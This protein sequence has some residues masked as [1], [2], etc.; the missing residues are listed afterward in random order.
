MTCA[1]SSKTLLIWHPSLGNFQFSVQHRKSEN[2]GQA[3]EISFL[4]GIWRLAGLS[5]LLD[6]VQSVMNAGWIVIVS[7][8]MQ[9][10]CLANSRG[11]IWDHS[12]L[13]NCNCGSQ[14]R[15]LLLVQLCG[16]LK[17]S[18]TFQSNERAVQMELGS[19]L[20]SFC[21][22]FLFLNALPSLRSSWLSHLINQ[23]S[24]QGQWSRAEQT[25]G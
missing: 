20:G 5:E 23:L 16:N 1:W 24:S 4:C 10:I 21:C 2:R 8:H 25:A 11:Q 19:S 7:G 18:W 17:T 6:C 12:G 22:Q 15:L 3:G 9:S 13:C 14:A